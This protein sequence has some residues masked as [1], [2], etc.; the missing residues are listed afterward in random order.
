MSAGADTAVTLTGSAFTNYVGDFQWTSVVALTASNGSVVTLIPDSVTSSVLT[1]TIPGTTAAGN[2]E[3]R[4]A[5]S[6]ARSNPV[7]ISVIPSVVITGDSCQKKKGILN[8]T[9]SGFGDKPAGTN[10]YI[11]VAIN[12]S[13]VDEADLMAWNDTQIRVSVSSCPK[14]ATITVNA[15]F[16][17]ASNGDSGGPGDPPSEPEICDDG[18]D[19]D[20][21]GAVDCDDRDCRRDR[22][23]KRNK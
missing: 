2:Y 1:V 8:V 4:A 16:G 14:N 7:V 17:S 18:V 22:V 5:K 20:G 15:T 10:D 11:N 23:C 12:G 19:N 21:D 9:G 13:T 6:T 3:L